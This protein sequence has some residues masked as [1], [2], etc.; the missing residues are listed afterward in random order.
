MT[1]SLGRNKLLKQK[2]SARLTD[3]FTLDYN[4]RYDFADQPYRE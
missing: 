3:S 1:H 2:A 4:S